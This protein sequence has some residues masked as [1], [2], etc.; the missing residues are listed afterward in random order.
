MYYI[1]KLFSNQGIADSEVIAE[2]DTYMDAIQYMNNMDG[3]RLANEYI[4]VD[5]FLYC[6][7]TNKE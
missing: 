5:G 7:S 1:K 3:I 4:V 2:V 6:F